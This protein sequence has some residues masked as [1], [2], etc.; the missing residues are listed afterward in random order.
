MRKQGI[1][2]VMNCLKKISLD[3]RK[4]AIPDNPDSIGLDKI[5]QLSEKIGDIIFLQHKSFPK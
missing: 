1:Q 4:T 3:H 2:R 5:I